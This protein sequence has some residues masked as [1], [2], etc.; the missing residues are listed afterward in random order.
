MVET[1]DSIRNQTYPNIQCIIIN[2]LKDDGCQEV[3]EN[4]LKKHQYDALFIQNETPL[5]ITK[6]LN[7]GLKYTHGE[8]FQGISCD[9]VLHPKKISD[10]VEVFSRLGDEYACVF[11]DMKYIDQNSNPIDS[12]KTFMTNLN[13]RFPQ[14][15]TPNYNFEQLLSS[16]NP[17]PAPAVLIS[18]RAVLEV[19]MYDVNLD[20]EDYS[21]NLELKKHN[22]KF[23]FDSNGIVAD[24][25]ILNDSLS[26]VFRKEKF[27]QVYSL[28]KKHKDHLNT[29]DAIYVEKLRKGVVLSPNP[30][31][32][33][34]ELFAFYKITSHKNVISYLKMI[35]NFI[36]GKSKRKTIKR[37]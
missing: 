8:Y 25:R 34:K 5:S 33:L 9:D 23:F 24:Y 37:L 26:T 7:L 10:Q 15:A 3:I 30:R 4:W 36:I 32:F 13:E 31:I 14:A 2:N 27:H 19:G 16:T 35:V 20:I 12:L 29:K 18:T 11:G 21:M 1:L 17:I 22:F 6:N 28:L